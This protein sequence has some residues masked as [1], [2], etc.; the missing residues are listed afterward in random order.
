M[1]ST[2]DYVIAYKPGKDHANADSLSR[3]PLNDAP[4]DRSLPPELLWLMNTLRTD[5][6]TP[7][8]I[9][10]WTEHDPLLSKVRLSLLQGWRTI[11]DDDMKPFNRRKN[12]LS[13]QDGCILWGTRVVIPKKG[14]SKVL[15]QLHEGHPGMS[16]MK[17]LAQSIVWWPGID[18]DIVSQVQSCQQCQE[19]QKSPPLSP[20]QPWKW[21]DQPWSRLHIDHAGPFMGKT[22]LIVVDAHSK[23]LEAVSVPSTSLQA[24]I[25]TLHL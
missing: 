4:T 17:G 13:I 15:D 16:R 14:Q 2:Y 11:D 5:P 9:R 21:P 23:W 18:A 7:R 10:H 24:T 6:V 1:L 25:Q 3:L 19:N 22:F 8:D 20:L 12:E